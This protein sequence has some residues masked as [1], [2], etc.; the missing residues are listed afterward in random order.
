MNDTRGPGI[1]SIRVFAAGALIAGEP[2]RP[3]P[4]LPKQ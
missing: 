2:V 1:G 3:E 4:R